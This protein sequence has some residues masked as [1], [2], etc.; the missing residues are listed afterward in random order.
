MTFFTADYCDEH[1]TKIQVLGPGYH[2]Y[3]GASRCEGRIVT[4]KLN[5]HNGDLIKLLRDVD[6]SGQVVVVD[7]DAQYYAVV[8]EKLMTFAKQNNYRGIVING[9][10]RDT[11]QIKDIDVALFALG[12]CPRKYMEATTGSVN[13][14][15]SFSGVDFVPGY[16]L[17]ADVDGV[18]VTPQ[19]F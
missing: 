7:V 11:A 17:Y 1:H 14:P 19:P 9:Y 6:G 2:S 13:V 3:G 4:V 8:G 5:K 16:Y 18:I 15:V 10:V 12:T